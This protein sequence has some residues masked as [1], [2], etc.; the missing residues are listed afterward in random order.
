MKRIIRYILIFFILFITTSPLIIVSANSANLG[1]N[2]YVNNLIEGLDLSVLEDFLKQITSDSD[3]KNVI[4]QAINGNFLSFDD[5]F[6]LVFDCIKDNYKSYFSIFLSLLSLTIVY[7]VF[8]II[9]PGNGKFID[10]IFTAC[11]C[12]IAVL[13][14]NESTKIINSTKEVIDGLS[15][16]SQ[17][18]FPL[19][20]TLLVSSGANASSGLYSPVCVLLSNGINALINQ[21]LFPIVIAV[22][23]ISIISALSEKYTLKGLNDFFAQVFKWII[24]LTVAVFSIFISVKGIT[25]SNYDLISLRV[26]KYAVGSG[27]PL[28]GGIAKEGV[29]LVLTATILLKNAIGSIAIFIVFFI[30]IKP[31]L[32][33]IIFSLLLK[34]LSAICSPIAD[35]RISSLFISMAKVTSMLVSLLVMVFV[36]YFLTM[37][38]MLGTNGAIGG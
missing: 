22:S 18:I 1:I 30:L 34:L 16:E 29:D 8:T 14:F 28:I 23:L 7:S 13:V 10:I 27:L 2:D 20:L 25:A 5:I 11:Y 24:G 36:I 38:L 31:L 33:I 17:A 4:I 35:N 32:R 21:I 9:K 6:L 12:G 37:I 3:I 19:L 15:K 26:L